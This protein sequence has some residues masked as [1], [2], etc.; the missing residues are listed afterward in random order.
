[1]IHH[2]PVRSVKWLEVNTGS[3]WL[4]SSPLQ[5]SWFCRLMVHAN[6]QVSLNRVYRWTV[7]RSIEYLRI[8]HVICSWLRDWRTGP[9]RHESNSVA[10]TTALALTLHKLC[11]ASAANVNF[12]LSPC[13]LS[14]DIS[15]GK[16]M[17]SR[18]PDKRQPFK[19]SIMT[20]Y[21]PLHSLIV[22]LLIELL[23]VQYV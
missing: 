8:Q 4:Q 20:S 18:Y 11:R 12:E 19:I 10:W 22:L 2:S 16:E 13:S 17:M 6:N 21:L 3:C 15:L 14:I 9:R 23:S 1:M 5:P 7:W